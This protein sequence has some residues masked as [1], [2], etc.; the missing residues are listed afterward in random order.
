MGAFVLWR[1]NRTGEVTAFYKVLL[2]AC[3]IMA[4]IKAFVRA[5]VIHNGVGEVFRHPSTL[6]MYATFAV[7]AILTAWYIRKLSV[8]DDPDRDA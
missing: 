5:E 3:F 2:W 4:T 7:T 8:R 6:T 1:R